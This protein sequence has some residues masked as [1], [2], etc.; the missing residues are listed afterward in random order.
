M[1]SPP[2]EQPGP[3]FDPTSGVSHVAAGTLPSIDLRSGDNRG[4][5]AVDP[6][7]PGP[8]APRAPATGDTVVDAA[9]QRLAATSGR[10][11]EE[12]LEV[13]DAVH[14]TLQ[15]RLGDVEG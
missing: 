5:T 14:A 10:P 7:G 15:D 9:V 6:S 12:Q 8:D 2:A 11:V 3:T 4:V 1:T 13:Y